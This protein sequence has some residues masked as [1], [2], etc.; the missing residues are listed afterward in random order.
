[1]V[2]TEAFGII[3]ENHKDKEFYYLDLKPD[4]VI[5]SRGR[6]HPKRS[7]GK[8]GPRKCFTE[9]DLYTTRLGNWESTEVEEKF[10]GKI[11][12]SGRDAVEYF[13]SLDLRRD[14]RTA[15]DSLL[16]YMT[17][18]KLRTP[19]GLDYLAG[20][21]ELGDKNTVLTALQ[22]LQ[23]VYVAIWTE[24]VWSIA[25]ASQSAT[26]FIISDH[27]VTVYNEACKPVSE[28][29]RGFNDPE[30]WLSGTH[31]LFP[32]SLDKILIQTNLSWVRNPYGDPLESRP[33]PNLFRGA[34]F[35][36][37]DIQTGRMLSETEVNEI[38]FIIKK[39]AYRYVAAGEEEWLYPERKMST[40]NW[41][42]LGRGYLLFP[43]PRSVDFSNEVILGYDDGTYRFDEY[44]RRPWQPDYGS[45]DRRDEEWK[46]FRA[47]QGEYARVF[48]PQR[49]GMK[50]DIAGHRISEDGPDYHA[51]LLSMEREFRPKNVRKRG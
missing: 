10:F 49:R 42:K 3:P 9:D 37:I 34:V 2:L 1:M 43:E 22:Q 35:S 47:F 14:G 50:Q 29:C 36:F 40:R 33:N 20:I 38:N 27:P 12:A 28:W 21:T 31:T 32:L 17:V 51:H 11:D 24:C 18:Q 7:Q 25:D 30:I 6:K 15:Y 46:T 13:T 5:D 48:G 44:G 26:K 23:R 45:K 8:L 19:K 4:I 16:L 41:S 39:R